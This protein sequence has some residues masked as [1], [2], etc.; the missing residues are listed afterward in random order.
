MS[1]WWIVIQVLRPICS[2]D[3]DDLY[4]HMYTNT[5]YFHITC[6]TKAPTLNPSCFLHT[7]IVKPPHP[8][9]KTCQCQLTYTMYTPRLIVLFTLYTVFIHIIYKHRKAVL[10]RKK[11][12]IYCQLFAKKSDFFSHGSTWLVVCENQMMFINMHTFT[13][14]NNQK[15][16]FCENFSIKLWILKTILGG[17]VVVVTLCNTM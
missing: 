11:S 17:F 3:F 1:I 13:F 14:N 10:M 4:T 15:L 12:F 8:E 9:I 2:L 6:I 7:H 16:R 5:D